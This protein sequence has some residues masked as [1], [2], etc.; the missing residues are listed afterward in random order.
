MLWVGNGAR[1]RAGGLQREPRVVRVGRTEPRSLRRPPPAL[2]SD[3]GIWCECWPARQSAG[4]VRLDGRCVPGGRQ[5]L[6]GSGP[7]AGANPGQAARAMEASARPRSCKNP[8]I[9][10]TQTPRHK[11]LYLWERPAPRDQRVDAR[12]AWV[13]RLTTAPNVL[14]R[15]VCW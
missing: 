12:C 11:Y 7:V 13:W 8:E 4:A 1:V 14:H 5:G 9:I 10:L 6:R 15:R 3:W 2:G